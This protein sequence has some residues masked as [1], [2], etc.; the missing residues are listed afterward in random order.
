MPWRSPMPVS[1]SRDCCRSLYSE[2]ASAGERGSR[3]LPLLRQVLGCWR[4]PPDAGR[5]FIQQL[6]VHQQRPLNEQIVVVAD[7]E[8][9]VAAMPHQTFEVVDLMSLASVESHR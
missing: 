5:L 9:T 4:F 1:C 7:E 2:N 3:P 6:E 8:E